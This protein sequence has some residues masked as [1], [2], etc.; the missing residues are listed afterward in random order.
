M[1]SSSAACLSSCAS[2]E[3]PATMVCAVGAAVRFYRDLQHRECGRMVWRVGEIATLVMVLGV[4]RAV[5][6]LY[7]CP[8]QAAVMLAPTSIPELVDGWLCH[9]S[10]RVA[11]SAMSSSAVSLTVLGWQSQRK[12]GVAPSGSASRFQCAG[13]NMP[14]G[15]VLGSST[16]P[17]ELLRRTTRCFFMG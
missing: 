13:A 9:R 1:F 3:F 17:V 7:R 10:A 5:V 11:P 4:G 2:G 16:S 8:T 12:F 14:L 15:H 6:A